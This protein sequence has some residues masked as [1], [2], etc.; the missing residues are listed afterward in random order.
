MSPVDVKFEQEDLPK[1]HAALSTARQAKASAKV[2]IDIADNG[3]VI[4]VH[5]ETKRKFK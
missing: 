3:G 1:I 5:L 4:A 2:T